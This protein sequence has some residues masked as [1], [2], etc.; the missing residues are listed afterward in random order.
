M[1]RKIVLVVF[2]LFVAVIVFGCN[3]KEIAALNGTIDSLKTENANL[4][5][6]TASLHFTVQNAIIAAADQLK[7]ADSTTAL[8]D[9]ANGKIAGLKK[10]VANLKKD[11]VNFRHVVDTLTC[12]AEQLPSCQAKLQQTETT[13]VNKVEAFGNLMES[14]DS[15]IM[16]ADS[17]EL[18][19]DY[20]WLMGHRG[21]PKVLFARKPIHPG[22]TL[23][24]MGI[25]MPQTTRYLQYRK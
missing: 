4:T 12:V 11:A 5:S 8:L 20:W 18:Q 16:H 23:E 25:T 21:F 15:V 19:L 9:V 14:R 13:L 7:R 10:Q 24:D 2:V 3:E 6:D 17:L 22:F 1:L